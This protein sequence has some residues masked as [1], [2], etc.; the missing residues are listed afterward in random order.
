MKDGHLTLNG[1]SFGD[2]VT[3]QSVRKTHVPHL[4][5]LCLDHRLD[6]IS[7]EV[8]LGDCRNVAAARTR[9]RGGGDFDVGGR[10]SDRP[11]DQVQCGSITAAI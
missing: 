3:L 1:A 10:S 2:Y 9:T 7:I 5:V 11:P 8:G 4:L 6:L